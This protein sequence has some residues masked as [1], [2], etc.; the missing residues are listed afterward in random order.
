MNYGG[1]VLRNLFFE[2]V[3]IRHLFL[4]AYKAREANLHRLS[5]QVAVESRDVHLYDAVAI[6]IE[7][8]RCPF[9]REGVC[10]DGIDAGF[11]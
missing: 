5:V 7:H 3:Q 11:G 6:Y 10:H 8:R 1:D 2:F 4:F 9:E